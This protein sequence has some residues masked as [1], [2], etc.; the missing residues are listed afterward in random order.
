MIVLHD[1]GV[2]TRR[3]RECL[4][5]QAFEE[6]AVLVAEQAMAEIAARTGLEMVILR[7]LLVYGA[8]V[9]AKFLALMRAAGCC[10]LRA[11]RTAQLGLHRQSMQRGIQAVMLASHA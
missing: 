7:S 11:L 10:R 6:E 1:L 4:A 3:L 5:V 2:D 9:K 8:G